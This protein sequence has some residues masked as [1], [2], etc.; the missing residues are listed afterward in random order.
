MNILKRT[1]LSDS[2]KEAAYM[3]LHIWKEH[4]HTSVNTHCLTH[5][6]NKPLVM[7]SN[8]KASAGPCKENLGADK[9]EIKIIFITTFKT[10]TAVYSLQ[11]T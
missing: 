2:S 7:R 6:M 5:K 1:Y 3:I 4:L 9:V 11:V 10:Q 8:K